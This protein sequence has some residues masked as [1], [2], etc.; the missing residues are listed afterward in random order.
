MQVAVQ[1]VAF[2]QGRVLAVETAVD[3][4]ADDEGG[5][6][7]AVVGSGAVVPD[8]ATEL[9]PD[10]DDGV[11]GLAVFLQVGHEVADRAGNLIPQAA[12]D[13][14]LIAVGVETAVLGVIDAGA[15]VGGHHLGGVFEGLG[16][17]VVRIF[18]GGRVVLGGRP[19]NVRAFER[20]AAGLAQVV[21]YG[22]LDGA[23]VHLAESV[24]AEAADALLLNVGEQPVGFQVAHRR[25]RNARRAHGTGQAATEVHAGDD[26]PA[27]GVE[28]ADDA[29]QPALGGDLFRLA[30][31]PDVHAAEVRTVRVGIPDAVDDGDLAFVPKRLDGRHVGV[32]SEPPVNGNHLVSGDSDVGTEV[33]IMSIRV[34]DNGVQR[35]IRASQLDYNEGPAVI[36]GGHLAKASLM[37]TT[38]SASAIWLLAAV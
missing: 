36:G 37:S 2:R 33:V 11:V 1:L 35:V 20:V 10:E 15:E 18:H 12:V 9:G 23:A 5:T 19:Q 26:V 25:Y 24:E 30:G 3:L 27:L 29:A 14:H 32:E 38:E 13:F 7:R 21:H 31:V 17:G 34:G 28:V 22:V 4:V 16:D 6:A 8:A